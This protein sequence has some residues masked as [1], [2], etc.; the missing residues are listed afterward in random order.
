MEDRHIEFLFF[1]GLRKGIGRAKN[2]ACFFFLSR[3]DR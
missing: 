2:Y 1:R 3:R